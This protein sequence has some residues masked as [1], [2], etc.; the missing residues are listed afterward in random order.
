MFL[1]LGLIKIEKLVSLGLICF[2]ESNKIMILVDLFDM[3]RFL[4]I[5][6]IQLNLFQAQ[7][8]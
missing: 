7:P 8:C 6:L 5:Q 3:I 2:I 4:V 1:N